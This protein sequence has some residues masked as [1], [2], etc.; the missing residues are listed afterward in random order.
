MH[1]DL[2]KALFYG[3]E[4]TIIK[5]NLAV[6]RQMIDAGKTDLLVSFTTNLQLLKP[7][8]LDLVKH[9]SRVEITGSID[10]LGQVN[11]YIRYP[12]KW[13]AVSEN[14][15]KLH[16]MYPQIFLSII[17]VV[18]VAN[19]FSF[20]DLIR[21]IART[22]PDRQVQV[23]PTML[24]NPPYLRPDILT[25][26]LRSKSLDYID[27]ALTDPSIVQRNKDYLQDVRSQIA[28]VHPDAVVLRQKFRQYTAYLDRT[29]KT[30]FLQ[31]FPDLRELVRESE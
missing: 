1:A 27:S 25:D 8:I 26:S 28:R 15:L 31:T 30:D 6:L 11:D 9:F 24:Q 7:E 29:R 23:M 17:Y 4:P 5:S 14:L 18:Q 20:V 3:G 12:S 13:Q 21:W 16:E 10:G 2:E 19:I 22:M